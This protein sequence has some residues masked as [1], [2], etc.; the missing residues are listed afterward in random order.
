LLFALYSH[1]PVWI[2]AALGGGIVVL[3][4]P[5]SRKGEQQIREV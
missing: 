5:L 4:L 1:A 2:G 3:M